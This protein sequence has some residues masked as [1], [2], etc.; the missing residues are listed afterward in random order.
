MLKTPL[1]NVDEHTCI[2]LSFQKLN[3]QAILTC[4]MT[5][6]S[7]NPAL[8]I[9]LRKANILVDA[10]IYRP[11]RV[12][13]HYLDK[14]GGSVVV[15]EE[16]KEFKEFDEPGKGMGGGWH[17]QADEVARCVRDGKIESEVWGWDKTLLEMKIFDEVSVGLFNA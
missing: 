12:K 14:E 13:V 17:L 8:L 2:S 9:R 1:T 15:K 4:G 11:H 3:A 7:P 16:V 6:T 10:P 5:V